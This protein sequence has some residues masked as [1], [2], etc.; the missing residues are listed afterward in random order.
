MAARNAQSLDFYGKIVDQNNQAVSNV[1]VTARVGLYSGITHSGEKDYDTESDSAGNFSF[2]GIHGAGA[3]FTL[4]KEGYV[5]DQRQASSSRPADYAPDP[6]KPVIFKMWKLNGQEPMTACS[7]S[8]TIPCDGKT[9]TFNLLTGR[10]KGDLVVT[11]TRD[12]VNIDRSKPFDW[13]LTV[14]IANGGLVENTDTYPN[15][16][17]ADG[18][19]QSITITMPADDKNWASSL[20]RSYYFQSGQMY[21]RM[22]INVTA[23][24]QPPPT[25]FGASIYT[26]PSGSR[27]LEFD[28]SKQINQ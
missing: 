13:T 19:Q 5:Y 25:F 14:G 16:A 21:G 9:M 18:Y 15:E 12:P 6:N 3:G 17:P 2:T 10:G 4:Q 1:K 26:N 24:F 8:T 27:N 11:L 22:T 7:I 23:N 28:S 20:T